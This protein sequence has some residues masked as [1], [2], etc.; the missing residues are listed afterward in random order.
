MLRDALIEADVPDQAI[1]TIPDEAEAVAAALALAEPEDLVLVFGDNIARCWG[2]ITGSGQIDESD[3]ASPGESPAIDDAEGAVTGDIPGPGDSP[4]HAQ[5]A[6]SETASP[7]LPPLTVRPWEDDPA[8][9]EWRD[10]LNED[11][12]IR[13]ERGVR[14]AREEE[15]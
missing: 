5:M 1:R 7:D 15:D 10:K 12:V 11:R 9:D 14:L 8:F 4:V 3:A 6:P 2:Q 13:D